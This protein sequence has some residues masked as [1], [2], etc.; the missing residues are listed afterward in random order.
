MN[1]H[2]K[3][4]LFCFVEVSNLFLVAKKIIRVKNPNK[5]KN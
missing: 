2:D 1:K 4:I 3:K 5:K